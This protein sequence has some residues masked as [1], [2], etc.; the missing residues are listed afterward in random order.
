MSALLQ[1][2]TRRFQPARQTQSGER[3]AAAG[4]W[5][6]GP[7]SRDA[8]AAARLGPHGASAPSG[9]ADAGADAGGAAQRCLAAPVPAVAAGG[10]HDRGQARAQLARSAAAAARRDAGLAPQQRWRWRHDGAC[11]RVYERHGTVPL[12]WREATLSGG[13]R[14]PQQQSSG[15]RIHGAVRLSAPFRRRC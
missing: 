3:A 4:R 5:R 10:G 14:M 2:A 6:C 9:S 8:A 12:P 11:G 15:W 7:H 1:L 13:G